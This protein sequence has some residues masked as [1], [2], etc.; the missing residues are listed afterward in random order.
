ML[1]CVPGE[2]LAGRDFGLYGNAQYFAEPA[3]VADARCARLVDG[4]FAEPERADGD[5]A[6]A[7]EPLVARLCLA[8]IAACVSEDRNGSD[9]DAAG[10]QLDRGARRSPRG[11]AALALLVSLRADRDRRYGVHSSS[12]GAEGR[13]T[14]ARDPTHRREIRARHRWAV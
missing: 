3:L 2:R 12:D 14:I 11:L 4:K 13:R 1:L 7:G 9:C 10:A 5:A 8:R 6:R